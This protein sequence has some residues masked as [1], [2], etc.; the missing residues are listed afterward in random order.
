MTMHRGQKKKLQRDL[1]Y[2]E[3]FVIQIRI[4]ARKNRQWPGSVTSQFLHR[5][6]PMLEK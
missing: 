2:H 5:Q 4:F 3:D 6:V 1:T